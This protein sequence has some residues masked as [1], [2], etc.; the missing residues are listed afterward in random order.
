[1]L[2]GRLILVGR[3]LVFRLWL[4]F[5]LVSFCIFFEV[6]WVLGFLLYVIANDFILG[7]VRKMWDE[8]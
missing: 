8:K 1:M 5:F 4:G 2:G 6:E 7:K 3:S